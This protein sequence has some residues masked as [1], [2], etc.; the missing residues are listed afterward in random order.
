LLCLFAATTFAQYRPYRFDHWTTDNGL[1]QNT[2]R[3][4][5]QTRDGYLWLTTF[6]GLARFDGVRFTV[7]DKSNTKGPSSNRFTALYE[8][9]DGALWAG[10]EDGGLIIYRHGVFTSYTTAD[11]FPSNQVSHLVRDLNG[12]LLITTPNGPVYMRKGK[13][14]PAP[15][16]YQSP[17]VKFYLGPSGTQW[18]IDAHGVRQ[19]KDGRVT[20]YPIKPDF[21]HS[22]TD[23]WPHEDSQGDLWLG[24]LS[25]LYR[26]RDGRITRYTA[27]DGLPPDV[28][29]RPECEDDDGGLWFATGLLYKEGIGLARF[30]DGRFTVYGSGAGLPLTTIGPIFKDREGTIWVGT[31]RGLSRLRKQLITAYSTESGLAHGEVYPLLQARNG[32]IWIGTI[33]GL[34]RFRDGRFENHPLIETKRIVQALWEDGAGRL[35]IGVITGLLRYENGK[36]ENLS[37]AIMGATAWAIRTDRAGNLWVA[38]DRGVF[39]FDGDRVVAHHTTKDGL[40]GDDVKAI[41]EDRHGTLWFGTY[42]GLARFKDGRFVSYTTAAGLASNRVRSIYEDADGTFWIGT[43]DD[44]LSRFRD[45]RFFNYRMEHGLYNNGVFQILEDRRGAFW[46]S[47]NKGIYRVSRRELNDFADGRIPKIN[48]IAYGKQDGM[49]N[50]E[51]NGGRQP[52]GFIARDGKFWFPTMAGVVVIDP[53]AVPVNPQPPPVLIESVMLERGRVDF[54]NGVTIELGQRDLEIG[55]TGLSF[56]KSEQ[57]KFKAALDLGVRGFV[58]KDGAANEIVGC[59]KSVAAGQSFFSPTLSG[60][61]LARRHRA[62][63]LAEEAPSINDL[64]ASERRVLRLIAESKTNKDIA[65]ELFI[66]VR[67]VE[68]H[69]SNICSK[70]GLTGKNAL[71]T[72]ALTHKSEL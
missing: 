61:L 60:H 55:Y 54:R 59:I 36:L 27:P 1:P 30:K 50:S 6:D 22:D 64:T 58:V 68:H 13:F 48:C 43:Y 26:L 19:V 29:L 52:A 34:S 42:G 10:T 20:H 33:Q 40:P 56:I 41:H 57:V 65:A 37:E 47:C 9:K 23:L 8:D 63:A 70:L 49:L 3:A 14:I 5:V 2:V 21:I 7:F 35:W 25:S 38:S 12:E 16:E 67:T 11:G 53:E 24:D 18:T 71:L 45:G 32:R 15:A 51:C 44:G 39:K 66:S 72:F 46:I 62:D 17:D 69:R 28:P 4:I 31:S